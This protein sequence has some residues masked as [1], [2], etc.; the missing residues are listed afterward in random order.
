MSE[1]D[2]IRLSV[3]QETMMRRWRGYDSI[4]YHLITRW[5]THTYFFQVAFNT[6]THPTIGVGSGPLSNHHHC[7]QL[8]FVCAHNLQIVWIYFVV[9]F[10]NGEKMLRV[11]NIGKASEQQQKICA[12]KSIN[13][14]YNGNSTN[15]LAILACCMN[16][17]HTHIF[18]LCSFFS[19]FFLL[20]FMLLLSSRAHWICVCVVR[21]YAT[22]SYLYNFKCIGSMS[23]SLW[24]TSCLWYVYRT[25]GI[26]L[27]TSS[28]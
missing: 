23:K 18:C 7:E 25:H 16:T 14:I 20:F 27:S 9:R 5:N 17:E 3:E 11:L 2:K 22:I 4:H 10:T 13:L 26:R 19:F 8:T 24:C 21:V 28:S 1:L 15:G 12:S 6:G